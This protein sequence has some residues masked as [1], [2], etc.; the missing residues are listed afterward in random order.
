MATEANREINASGG[1]HKQLEKV[2]D[3]LIYPP[4]KDVLTF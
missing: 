1:K 4:L 3:M 2:L